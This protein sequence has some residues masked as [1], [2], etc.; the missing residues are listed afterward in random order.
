MSLREKAMLKYLSLLFVIIIA[1]G[2][3]NDTNENI[4][5][6]KRISGRNEVQ[7]KLT[8]KEIDSISSSLN[9]SFTVINLKKDIAVVKE[10]KKTNPH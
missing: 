8:I 7:R 3:N 5:S 1:S 6:S 9:Y 4:S 2:C 10:E